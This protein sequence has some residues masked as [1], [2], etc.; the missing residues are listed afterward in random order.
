MTHKQFFFSRAQKTRLKQREK[1]GCKKIILRVVSL[2][3]GPFRKISPPNIFLRFVD[4]SDEK[5]ILEEFH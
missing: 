3:L 2:F 4:F 5:R 1:E